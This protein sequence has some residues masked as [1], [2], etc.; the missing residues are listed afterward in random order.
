[1]EREHQAIVN[2][3]C[4]YLENIKPPGWNDTVIDS[5]N[6]RYKCSDSQERDIKARGG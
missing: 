6:K 3:T 2:K 5:L 1:M 4:E